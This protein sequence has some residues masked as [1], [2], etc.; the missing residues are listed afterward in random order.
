MSWENALFR[1]VSRLAK[2]PPKSKTDSE[3]TIRAHERRKETE[4]IVSICKT[5][6]TTPVNVGGEVHFQPLQRV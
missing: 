3:I 4:S 1:L 2:P 6:A 5:V